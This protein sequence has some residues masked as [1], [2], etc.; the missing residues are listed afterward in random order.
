MTD[1]ACFV[2]L[3]AENAIHH[4]GHPVMEQG[5][6]LRGLGSG[7]QS[8]QTGVTSGYKFGN[9]EDVSCQHSAW[10][11]LLPIFVLFFAQF[12]LKRLLVFTIYALYIC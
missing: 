3:W 11:K 6:H 10:S 5:C 12:P 4:G 2:W 8:R 7:A 9:A 1:D